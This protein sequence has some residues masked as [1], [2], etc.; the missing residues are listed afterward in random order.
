MRKI[1]SLL[2]SFLIAFSLWYYVISVVSPGSEETFYNIPV[3]LENESA[4]EDRGLMITSIG[5][6][7]VTLKLSGNRSDLNK[8]NASNITIKA[9]LATIYDAGDNIQL[10]FTI[11]YPGTVANNAFVEESRTPSTVSISVEKR[12]YKDVPVVINYA[13]AVP[14]GYT[15]KVDEETLDLEAV[16]ISGPHSVVSTIAQACI[17]VDL[18]DQTETIDQ[19]FKVTLCDADGEP[20][21][22]SLITV[23]QNEVNL[24]LPI[25]KVKSVPLKLNVI[26]GGGATEKTTSI[27]LDPQVIRVC[28]SAA[29]LEDLKEIVLGTVDLAEYEKE[30]ELTFDINIPE[31]VTNMTGVTQ[32]NVKIE[33]PQLSTR[34]VKISNI[35]MLNVPEGLEAELMTQ[36]L[37]VTVRGPKDLIAKLTEADISV[38]VDLT[39]AEI[40][41]I[42]RKVQITLGDGFSQIGALGSNYSVYVQISEIEPEEK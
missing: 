41:T 3:V 28:G 24:R 4:L 11:A 38:K 7:S 5:S 12:D 10:D 14:A 40:G 30:T 13:G 35:E 20:V 17:E 2:V 18:T 33:F 26:D 22:A 25:L 9:N 29:A 32:A 8:V 1:A 23:Y 42:N 21:D 16:R 39:G 34:T 31:N 36:Q 37:D 27:T 6:T 19:S 15:A